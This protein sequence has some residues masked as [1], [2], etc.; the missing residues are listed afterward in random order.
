M[1]MDKFPFRLGEQETVIV[2]KALVEGYETQLVLD[3]AASQTVI[4]LNLLLILGYSPENFGEAVEVETANGI[5][6]AWPVKI[7]EIEGLGILLT[8][9]EI[10]T[11]DFFQKGLL[12]PHDG[13]L[14][15]DFFKNTVLTIDFQ[16]FEVRVEAG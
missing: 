1:K 9:F 4:D 3:T 6:E 12:S 13:V 15:L 7:R 5:M 8:G 2:V 11:Y 10:L 16:K 14:G